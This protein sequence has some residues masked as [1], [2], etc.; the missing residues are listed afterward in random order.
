MKRIV[1]QKNVCLKVLFLAVRCHNT[2]HYVLT[3]FPHSHTRLLAK[4]TI[5]MLAGAWIGPP[6]VYLSLFTIYSNETFAQQKDCPR[7]CSEFK[8]VSSIRTK[9]CIEM[10]LACS[11]EFRSASQVGFANSMP[12]RVLTL[13]LVAVPL[14]VMVVL[15]GRLLVLAMRAT[16][17]GSQ[18]ARRVKTHTL[19]ASLLICGTLGVC[20]I[21][22][23]IQWAFVQPM[24]WASWWRTLRFWE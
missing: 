23:V 19:T 11:R 24:Y 21:P 8:V 14:A 4:L 15:Y 5:P 3:A 20:W 13:C 1:L 6:V 7:A 2:G 10:T 18:G 17:P 16:L 22:A 12:V 9:W